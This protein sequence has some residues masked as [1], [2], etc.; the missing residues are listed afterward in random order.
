MLY[1]VM[2][3]I[4]SYGSN[5][6]T[7]HLNSDERLKGEARC[8]GLAVTVEP[9]VFKLSVPSDIHG[10]TA[11]IEPG[12]TE[13]VW[14]VLYEVPDHIIERDTEK[15]QR[16][17]SLDQIEAEGKNTERITIRVR[18]VSGEEVAAITYVGIRKEEGLRTTA[19]YSSCILDGLKSHGAPMVYVHKVREIILAN[20]PDLTRGLSAV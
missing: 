1:T 6:D 19:E 17:K 8:I 4:F 2:A 12:G 3:I 7:I 16:W 9:H 15:P 11:T 5:T 10:C 20:N 14:G 18:R 13:G